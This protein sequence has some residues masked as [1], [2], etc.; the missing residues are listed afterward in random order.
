MQRRTNTLRVNAF[1]LALALTVSPCLA[2]PAAAAGPTASGS[3][4]PGLAHGFFTEL[5]SGLVE[6]LSPAAPEPENAVL[7]S[8][9]DGTT[10]GVGTSEEEEDDCDTDDSCDLDPGG[11]GSIMD[12]NG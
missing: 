9:D 4:L 6:I 7:H 2:A 3:D 1:V 12:P 10:S 5:W 11:I 8:T